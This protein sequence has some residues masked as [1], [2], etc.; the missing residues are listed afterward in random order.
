MKKL[1]LKY[2]FEKIIN[3]VPLNIH[4]KSITVDAFFNAI[5]FVFELYEFKFEKIT[6]HT[7]CR[8]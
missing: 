7:K 3:K 4:K 8:S 1:E 5:I 6:Y 2:S